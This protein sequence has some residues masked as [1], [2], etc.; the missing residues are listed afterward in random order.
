MNLSPPGIVEALRCVAG[1]RYGKTTAKETDPVRPVSAAYVDAVLPYVAPQVRALIELQRVTGMRSGEVCRMRGCDLNTT[2]TVW[3]YTPARKTQH[4]TQPRGVPVEAQTIL[5]PWLRAD[6]QA[7]LFQPA[8]ADQW[9]REQRHKARKTPIG[10]GNRP[11]TNKKRQPAKSAGERYTTDSY[12][13]ALDYAIKRCNR[14][15]ADRG[16]Q[17]IRPGI[18]TAHNHAT[19]VKREHGMKS[20]AF[21]SPSRE[22]D[23]VYAEADRDR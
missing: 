4:R 23:Q 2:G 12:H 14:E 11:G 1:L 15:R 6:L 7:Y 9:R 5:R 3:T 22:H 13:G 19:M 21:A 18:R 10:Y 16:E 17:P 8:E 20:L